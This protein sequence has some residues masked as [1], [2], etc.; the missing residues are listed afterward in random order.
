MG[1]KH[2]Q[3][4]D[5]IIALRD[6]RV[7][8]AL[9][10]AVVKPLLE[11]I[12]ELRKDTEKNTAVINRLRNDLK[13]ATN[14]IKTL[15]ERENQRLE[16]LEQYARRDNLLIAGLPVESYAETASIT[17]MGEET[18]SSRT[19]KS[20]LKLFNEKLHLNIT[21]DDISIAHRLKTPSSAA[22]GPP[23]TIVK[24][25]NRKAREAVY[26]ARRLLK[27]PSGPHISTSPHIYIN[28]DLCKSVANVYKHARQAVK[29]KQ[30]IST[31]TSSCSVYVKVSA[32]QTS[33]PRKIST[34]ADL[35]EL[36]LTG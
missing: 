22:A 32:D 20:V 16:S 5:L 25:T 35:H 18:P 11:S 1:P 15:E 2:N 14:R 3:V 13:T 17:T 21:P 33:R 8:E 23:L 12:A 31:W 34:I 4:E 6:E 9:T 24:F 29:T 10:Q 26:G 27:P 36:L 7:L 30:I 28:E 19:E